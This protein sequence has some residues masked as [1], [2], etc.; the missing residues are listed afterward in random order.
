MEFRGQDPMSTS[1][2]AAPDGSTA[3]L[4][5]LT[6]ALNSD[7][8]GD[9]AAAMRLVRSAVSGPPSRMDVYLIRNEW[10][11][12]LGVD[13][14]RWIT[15]HARACAETLDL[16]RAV[17]VPAAVAGALSFVFLVNA[18]SV[19]GLVLGLGSL[20]LTGAAG[21][22]WRTGTRAPHA[23]TW[24]DLLEHATSDAIEREASNVRSGR[25]DG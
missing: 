21:W 7:E 19:L 17:G 1:S 22:A 11:P 18:F 14:L 6:G 3:A 23:R 12:Q 2:S 8:V 15:G 4:G 16:R 5:Y 9:D 20:V 10:G 24:T 13:D 25:V